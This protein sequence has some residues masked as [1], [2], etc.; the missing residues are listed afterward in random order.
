M[1][2]GILIVAHDNSIIKYTELAVIAAHLAKK[3]LNLPVSIITDLESSIHLKTVCADDLFDKI[4]IIEKLQQYNPRLMY[5][6]KINDF[7]NASRSI[8][9][10]CT[11][12][13]HTL[14]IDSDLL[15]FSNRF[16]QYWDLEENFLI[17]ESMIDPIN[18][19]LS[20]NDE[21][22][23]DIAPKLKWATAIMFKKNQQAKILF[24]LVQHIFENYDFYADTYFFDDRQFRNDIAFTL[25]EHIVNGFKEAEISLPS[26]YITMIEDE[27]ISI[28]GNKIKFL[29]KDKDTN[30]LTTLRDTDVHV[31]NKLDILKHKEQLIL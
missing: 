26:M 21:R 30:L 7:L 25:A 6:S 11:P 20:F 1:N 14:L 19:R 3:N 31:M 5:G 29:I 4:I 9:W 12:Y 10:E 13:E 15:I 17:C 2:R 16:N 22:V 27:I 18:K 8:A 23:S 28:D 24:D